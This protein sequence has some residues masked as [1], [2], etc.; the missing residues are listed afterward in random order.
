MKCSMIA[1]VIAGMLMTIATP[2][3]A[4]ESTEPRELVVLSARPLPLGGRV[5]GLIG[6]R[7][8]RQPHGLALTLSNASAQQHSRR[9]LWLAVAPLIV[10]GVLLIYAYAS[11]P[12]T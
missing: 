5:I 12:S 9:K 3:Q 2:L 10:V 8:R 1:T 11:V 6:E 4:A 7:T